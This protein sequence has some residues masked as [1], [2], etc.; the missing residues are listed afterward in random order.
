MAENDRSF[1]IMQISSSRSWGGMEMHLGI[2]SEKLRQRGHRVFTLC[3]RNS[4]TEEDLLRKNFQP[5]SFNIQGYLHPKTVIRLAQFLKKQNIDIVHAHYSRDLW[6]IVPAV[7]LA[8][9]IPVVLIKHIGTQK[10]KRDFFR[11]RI[12]RNVSYVIAI[13]EVIAENVRQT[14]PIS[15]NRV[16]VIQAEIVDEDSSRNIAQ[17][18][19][20]RS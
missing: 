2:L 17:P 13:S 8:G 4:K 18:F 7:K 14:H 16:G 9:G 6:T 12:Y 20:E 11:R 19:P 10:P 3:P 5:F 15:P 1:S